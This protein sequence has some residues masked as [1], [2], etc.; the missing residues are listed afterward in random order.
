VEGFLAWIWRV[1]EWLRDWFA[2]AVVGLVL[3]VYLSLLVWTVVAAG[4]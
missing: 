2:V 3:M 1:E 4:R